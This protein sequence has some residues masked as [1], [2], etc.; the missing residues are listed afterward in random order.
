MVM[1]PDGD[2]GS[3]VAPFLHIDTNEGSPRL[4]GTLGLG[5]PVRS[6]PLH[7]RPDRYPRPILG[8]QQL[9]IFRSEE[10]YTP[11]VNTALRM[12]GDPSLQANIY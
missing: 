7:A 2:D 11:M 3:V 9:Q 4:E 10:V 1:I 6:I 5:C 12:D 8:N